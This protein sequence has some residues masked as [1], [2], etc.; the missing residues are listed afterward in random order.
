ML[1]LCKFLQAL[2]YLHSYKEVSRFR[3]F[4]PC[5]QQKVYRKFFLD[6]ALLTNCKFHELM[7]LTPHGKGQIKTFVEGISG[8]LFFRSN[9]YLGLFITT[10]IKSW[11]KQIGELLKIIKIIIIS[12]HFLK[13]S[14]GCIDYN[15]KKTCILQ[16]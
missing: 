4:L 11:Q 6:C 5:F 14:L 12:G 3:M 10:V 16:P 1:H 2:W 13:P 9:K 8:C 7:K 15:E